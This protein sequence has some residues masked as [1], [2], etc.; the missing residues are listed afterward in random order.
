[1]SNNKKQKSHIDDFL[2]Y[3][4][5]E[6]KHLEVSLNRYPAE[7]NLAV[8][9]WRIMKEPLIKEV[10][11]KVIL[12]MTYK[13]QVDKAIFLA[14]TSAMRLHSIQCFSMLRYAVDSMILSCY[15]MFYPKE[16][17]EILSK[18]DKTSRHDK[19][20]AG[21][22]TEVS[23]KW[24]DSF[25]KRLSNRFRE[26]K[27]VVVNPLGSHVSFATTAYNAQIRKKVWINVFDEPSD[28]M[29]K[30]R[31]WLIA[32]T[33]LFYLGFLFSHAEK[34]GVLINKDLASEI[35]ALSKEVEKL[36]NNLKTV[37]HYGI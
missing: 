9:L 29:Q 1:M 31:L 18:R 28:K 23:Y 13:S 34:N 30:F 7:C 22:L 6:K 32:D 25:D 20:K 36:K 14:I 37:W 4:D 35:T 33:L 15:V 17:F 2:W 12:F 11:P 21:R 24:L 19:K 26:I 27:R 10:K 16:A 8:S 3:I 5:G